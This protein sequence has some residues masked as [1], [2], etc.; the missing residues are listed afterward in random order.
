MENS[1]TR[2]GEVFTLDSKGNATDRELHS[3]A[4][5]DADADLRYRKL[6]AREAVF[7]GMTIPDAEN[8]FGISFTED[9]RRKLSAEALINE[10]RKMGEHIFS[11]VDE[12]RTLLA[13]RD[14]TLITLREFLPV[15]YGLPDAMPVMMRRD[16][17][18]QDWPALG[19]HFWY[20][21]NMLYSD[22]FPG[23]TFVISHGDSD[24]RQYTRSRELFGDKTEY[25]IGDLKEALAASGLTDDCFLM[26]M[27]ESENRDS[28]VQQVSVEDDALVL[29]YR[30]IEPVEEY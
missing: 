21:E 5:D 15:V 7:D 25:T 24:W 12:I 14:I 1:E 9:E 19:I 13:E 29:S 18:P 23:G 2:K 6:T 3:H 16:G 8:T 10:R 30:Y 20:S 26:A 11:G 27:L 28:F 22:H 4:L 17:L